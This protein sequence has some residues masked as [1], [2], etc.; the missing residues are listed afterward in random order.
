MGSP[1]TASKLGI[2][3]RRVGE[4]TILE[5]DALLR[6]KLRFGRSSVTLTNAVNSLLAAGQKQILLNL[7]GV[8]SLGAK[9]LGD[10]VS[11][12]LVVRQGGGHFKLAN[13]TPMARQLMRVTNLVAVFDLFDSEKEAIES[14]SGR[15]AEVTAE[16]PS[17]GER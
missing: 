9:T 5:T 10:L 7:N 11:T 13:L 6:I 8:N 1:E 15:S 2:K 14:F 16:M 12:H 3:E 17:Q 4:V